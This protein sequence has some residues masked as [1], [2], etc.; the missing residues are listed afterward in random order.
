MLRPNEYFDRA[1]SGTTGSDP[2]LTVLLILAVA[3]GL[4]YLL[5]QLRSGRSR[6]GRP[7]R[8]ESPQYHVPTKPLAERKASFLSSGHAPA[9]LN[10]RDPGQ[11]MHAIA[12]V[13]FE[14]VPLLNRSEARLLPALEAVVRKHGDGHR[15]M[16]QTCLG[17]IL[18]PKGADLTDRQR[19]DA[20]F[21]VNAKRLDF[22]VFNRFGY[23]VVAIEYQGHAHYHATS[24]MRDAVK[25][26]ALRKAGVPFLELEAGITP[27]VAAARLTASL[28]RPIQARSA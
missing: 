21:S 3:V 16:A 15:L 18:R 7:H 11:Q 8:S 27:E 6:R 2:D 5:G 22:A 28:Q 4:L 10:L 12:Q 9:P 20:Y 13:G 14:T 25:R 24:F 17:E 23:L 19:D 1:A 26:E